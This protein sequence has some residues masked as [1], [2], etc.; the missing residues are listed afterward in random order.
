[1]ENFYLMLMSAFTSGIVMGTVIS[2]FV[3][4]RYLVPQEVKEN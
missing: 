4:Y 2:G 3:I 1:M